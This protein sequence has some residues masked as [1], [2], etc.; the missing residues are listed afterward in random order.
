MQQQVAEGVVLNVKE[1]TQCKN[2]NSK[3]QNMTCVSL[4]HT[5]LERC[6]ECS[7]QGYEVLPPINCDKVINHS[8]I[9]IYGMTLDE[10]FCARLFF[11]NFYALISQP[12]IPSSQSILLTHS[13]LNIMITFSTTQAAVSKRDATLGRTRRWSMGVIMIC[14]TRTVINRWQG[15]L[16]RWTNSAQYR[17]YWLCHTSPESWAGKG[18]IHAK[19]LY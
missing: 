16:V 11:F 12:T 4:Q 7:S 15:M 6:N 18:S 2:R 9:P 13:N 1:Q 17:S 5:K 14:L 10:F 3:P 8:A 19:M